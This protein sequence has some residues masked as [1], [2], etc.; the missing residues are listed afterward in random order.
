MNNRGGRGG[1]GV[2]WKRKQ[3]VQRLADGE[4]RRG[5]EG[6]RRK[7]REERRRGQGG[8]LWLSGHELRY[9]LCEP[10]VGKGRIMRTELEAGVRKGS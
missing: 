3:V 4:E 1:R 7:E 8:G 5:E 6:A 9:S 2:E 10:L